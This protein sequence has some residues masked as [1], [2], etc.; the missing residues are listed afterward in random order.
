MTEA[1]I[2]ELYWSRAESA[3]DET[4]SKYGKYCFAAARLPSAAAER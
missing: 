4:H 3:I 1:S 2:L